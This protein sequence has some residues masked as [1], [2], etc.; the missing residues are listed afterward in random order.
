MHNMDTEQNRKLSQDGEVSTLKERI[1]A[2]TI[3]NGKSM[4]DNLSAFL[5]DLLAQ[6]DSEER[7]L[8]SDF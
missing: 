8:E 4:H 5:V 1:D 6:T 7:R 3:S 2:E